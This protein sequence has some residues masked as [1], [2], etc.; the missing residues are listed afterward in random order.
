MPCFVGFL[1]VMMEIRES[2]VEHECMRARGKNNGK[3]ADIGGP[4]SGQEV[5]GHLYCYFN[6][7]SPFVK[8]ISYKQ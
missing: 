7:T 1:I 3:A 2:F 6:L 8:I 5:K 4:A